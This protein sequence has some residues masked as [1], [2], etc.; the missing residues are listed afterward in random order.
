MSF[1]YED[2]SDSSDTE[3]LNQNSANK[4][5]TDIRRFLSSVKEAG[6]TPQHALEIRGSHLDKAHCWGDAYKILGSQQLAPSQ[7]KIVENMNPEEAQS[8]GPTK[9]LLQRRP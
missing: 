6:L 4:M 9:P 1:T 8:N 3:L 5:K 2:V 7:T